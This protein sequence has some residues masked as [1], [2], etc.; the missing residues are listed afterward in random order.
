MNYNLKGTGLQ[1]TDEI[2]DYVEKKLQGADKFVGDDSTAHTDVE[3][4]Y[5]TSESREHYR[6][7]FTLQYRGVVHRAEAS[8]EKLH[9]AIDI[10]TDELVQELRRTKKKSL[11]LIRRGSATVKD[12]LR[13]FR[14]KP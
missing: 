6:A 4:V 13:G 8:G 2:R 10:A 14:T 7:E 3:V 5:Q 9:E 1:I 11:S 12:F